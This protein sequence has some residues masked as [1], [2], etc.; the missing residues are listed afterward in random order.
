M[1]VEEIDEDGFLVIRA[2]L[3]DIDIEHDLDV[4]VR[5]HLLEIRATRTQRITASDSAR[6]TEFSYGRFW[7]VLTLPDGAREADIDATYK[8]GILEVRVPLTAAQPT[9]G[10]HISVRQ[11]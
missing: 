3:P 11:A 8:H 9:E 2:E 6:H 10:R 1:R 4:Q 7:R 5:N